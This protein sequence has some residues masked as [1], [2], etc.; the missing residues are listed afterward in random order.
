MVKPAVRG[1]PVP[2]LRSAASGKTMER[3]CAADTSKNCTRLIHNID[4]PPTL[5]FLKNGAKIM[6]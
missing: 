3:D 5:N 6:I 1:S 4:I 2:D